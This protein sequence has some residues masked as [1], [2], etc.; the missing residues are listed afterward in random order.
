MEQV[1]PRLLSLFP[2]SSVHASGAP[3]DREAIFVSRFCPGNV[4]VEFS[5]NHNL[6]LP[7]KE[8]KMYLM[9]LSGQWGLVLG[10]CSYQI[11]VLSCCPVFLSPLVLVPDTDGVSVSPAALWD[12]SS[13]T[14]GVQLSEARCTS[15][16]RG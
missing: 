8:D 1:E 14:R 7:M 5:I 13:L 16:L 4:V 2:A 10:R 11:P 15:P 6:G 12:S 9:P 3:Y